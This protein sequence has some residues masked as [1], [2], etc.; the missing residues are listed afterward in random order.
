MTQACSVTFASCFARR[1]SHPP[2][3]WQLM[4]RFL[5]GSPAAPGD[6][7]AS[8]GPGAA[9]SP[10]PR[11]GGAVSDDHSDEEPDWV[12]ACMRACMSVCTAPV[13]EDPVARRC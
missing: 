4:S 12:R 10:A 6:A 3:A 5:L 13:T 1:D 11:T 2:S 7:P 9:T 8:A